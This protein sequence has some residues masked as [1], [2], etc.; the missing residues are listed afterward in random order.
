MDFNDVKLRDEFSQLVLSKNPSNG[1]GGDNCEKMREFCDHG[2]YYSNYE[3]DEE[4]EGGKSQY[5][6]YRIYHIDTEMSE[7]SIFCRMRRD[8]LIS[9]T[10]FYS[11]F[12]NMKYGCH[13]N[14]LQ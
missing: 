9:I 14:K 5:E 8:I 4:N 2:W 7:S 1:D 3:N 10:P 6:D 11:A 12:T 13:Q